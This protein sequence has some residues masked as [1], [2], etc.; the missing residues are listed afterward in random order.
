MLQPA[1]ERRNRFADLKINWPVF[2]L[3]Y[4]VVVELTIERMKYLVCRLLLEKK[5]IL[6]FAVMVVDKRSIET[7]TTVSFE[8]T[9]NHVVGVCVRPPSWRPMLPTLVCL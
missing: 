3:N 2:D 7:N 9:R 4:D 1:K 6:P 5:K 8:R